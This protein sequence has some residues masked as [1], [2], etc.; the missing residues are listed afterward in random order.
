MS[1]EIPQIINESLYDFR[2]QQ[3][4]NDNKE[5]ENFETRNDNK[6]K[7][8]NDNK[9]N[10][11]VKSRDEINNENEDEQNKS[12]TKVHNHQDILI[13]E[14]IEQVTKETGTV[15]E[16]MMVIMKEYN[17]NLEN[18]NNEKNKTIKSCE[19]NIVN[20]KIDLQTHE[21]K[22]KEDM[23]KI[24]TDNIQYI[25][26]LQNSGKSQKQIEEDILIIFKKTDISKNDII[27]N[28]K[29]IENTMNKNIIK[30]KK[31]SLI[32]INSLEQNKQDLYKQY[33]TD[34]DKHKD[35]LDS[36]ISNNESFRKKSKQILEAQEQ[37]SKLLYY[38]DSLINDSKSLNNTTIY[39][40]NKIKYVIENV[41]SISNK[42]KL[43]KICDSLSDISNNILLK[44]DNI[45]PDLNKLYDVSTIDEQLI[46]IK[47]LS[48]GLMKLIVKSNNFFNIINE[49]KEIFTETNINMIQDISTKNLMIEFLDGIKNFEY[50][51]KSFITIINNLLNTTNIIIN[52]ILETNITNNNLNNKENQFT[53]INPLF[54]I[55][56][57][58]FIILL[59]I[60]INKK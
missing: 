38:N 13:R 14:T 24:D 36:I 42:E 22:A 11:N 55:L 25:Q 34:K 10:K 4:N 49:I 31:E 41:P 52:K 35:M 9:E 33:N 17:S 54:I 18:I 51:V 7:I 56:F 23:H 37:F 50:N 5:Y 39:I 60:I 40:I 47:K 12:N 21:N 26:N 59:Y 28:I 57:I 15:L 20:L 46:N 32:K 27:K 53:N 58:I 19:E 3:N 48:L 1:E 30:L 6:N 16:S 43:N 44:I 29:I 8:N 45:K 2:N